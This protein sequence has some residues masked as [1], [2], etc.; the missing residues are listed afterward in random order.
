MMKVNFQEIASALNVCKRAVER[1]AVRESWAFTL[2]PVRGGQQK[3]FETTLLPDEV[4]L[5]AERWVKITSKTTS[6]RFELEALA[7]ELAKLAAEMVA[8]KARLKHIG[9]QL[10][11]GTE[12]TLSAVDRKRLDA[13]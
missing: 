11:S 4:R 13:K 5:T 7:D 2:Q 10:P 12:R 9:S 3:I 6:Q 8:L 1:R